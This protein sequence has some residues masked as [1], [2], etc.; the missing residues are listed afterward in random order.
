MIKVL[1]KIKYLLFTLFLGT[2]VY[3]AS[4]SGSTGLTTDTKSDIGLG[5]SE[6]EY[7]VYINPKDEIDTPDNMP[8][9]A[10]KGDIIDIIEVTGKAEFNDSKEFLIVKVKGITDEQRKTLLTPYVDAV[11]PEKI[12]AERKYSFDVDQLKAENNIKETSGTF[13]KIIPAE[14]IDTIKEKTDKTISYYKLK[15]SIFVL[16]QPVRKFVK[17]IIPDVYAT[18]LNIRYIDRDSA[19]GG[20]G[21]TNALS[22]ATAA[23]QSMSIWEN[24]RDDFGD[25]VGLDTIEEAVADSTSGSHTA[26]TTGTQILGW[27]TGS[28]NYIYVHTPTSSRHG[29]K[30][31]TTKYRIVSGASYCISINEDY[32]RLEGLQCSASANISYGYN[33]TASTVNAD[34]YI[35]DNVVNGLGYVRYGIN[36]QPIING[37]TTIFM[38]VYNNVISGATQ[39]TDGTAILAGGKDGTG[40]YKVMNNTAFDC[41]RGYWF[42]V[43]PY[44]ALLTN[45]LSA[46]STGNGFQNIARVTVTTEYNAS[47][48][49]T[50]DDDGGTGNRISQTFS[51]ADISNNDFHLTSSDAGAKDFGLTDPGSG[52]FSDDIDG[53]TRTGSWDIGADE[54]V[55]VVVGSSTPIRLPDLLLFY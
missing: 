52:L 48:D 28:A 35:S 41:D 16:T 10:Q 6:K 13:D 25:L 29:G 55:T 5:G 7:W 4:L 34:V 11:N 32:V 14:T 47:S 37:T 36:L 44:S 1:N 23:Y 18:T 42:S 50:A 8:G 54:Y 27:T 40:V 2:T 33:F 15:A 20:D 19:A 49:A 24:A 39:N 21:T 26:D 12:L 31:D 46:S 53:Q 9:R 22:G 38:N 43:G 30:W 45:N 17:S 51:F 3:A